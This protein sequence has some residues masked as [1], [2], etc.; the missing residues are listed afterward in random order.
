MP[1]KIYADLTSE[2]KLRIRFSI[3]EVNWS[4]G[5]S[6]GHSPHA[7]LLTSNLE[8]CLLC[9]NM[10]SE[11]ILIILN[12]PNQIISLSE[13]RLTGGRQTRNWG[14]F[15][16]GSCSSTGLSSKWL[17]REVNEHRAGGLEV[18][19]W[20]GLASDLARFCGGTLSV[21]SPVAEAEKLPSAQASFSSLG[22]I[23]GSHFP[24]PGGPFS[25]QVHG[26]FR[27]CYRRHRSEGPP[28]T[29]TLA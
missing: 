17:F 7:S 24:V 22:E 21:R 9:G 28:C 20:Q 4:L 13:C 5:N 19:I 16:R 12:L 18:C 27:R 23:R 1:R 3:W 11:W 14:A 6:V 15:S 2:E 8:T 26:C 25:I 29:G 10:Q